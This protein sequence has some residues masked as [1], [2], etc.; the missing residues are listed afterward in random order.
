[1]ETRANYVLVGAFALVAVFGTAFALLWLAKR[2]IDREFSYF[3]IVFTE[4]VTGLSR[5]GAVYFNGIGVGTVVNLKIDPLDPNR[6]LAQIRIDA[7]SPVKTTTRAK[8]AYQGITG[9]A[10]ILLAGGE[11]GDPPLLATQDQDPA[12][13]LAETSDLARLVEGSEDILTGANDVFIRINR[14]LSDQNL[15]RVADTLRHVDELTGTV[16]ARA[17]DLDAMLGN[18]RLASERLDKTLQQINNAGEVVNRLGESADA[19][20]RTDA[21]ALLEQSRQAVAAIT[22]L[23]ERGDQLIARNE[24][25]VERFSEQG[26]TELTRSTAELTRLLQS[27]NRIADSLESDPRSY[28]LDGTRPREYRPR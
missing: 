15:R 20:L 8:L 5:G 1:M 24:G 10:Y 28:L 16:A 7:E 9:I 14:M 26:L 17:E 22:A 18:A 23:A 2:S 12:R 25:A 4:S 21:P 19:L 11:P 27:L 13:I 3:E 6:V